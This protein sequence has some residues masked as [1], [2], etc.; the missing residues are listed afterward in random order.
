MANL[1]IGE[2]THVI[3]MIK[4]V[5]LLDVYAVWKAKTGLNDKQLNTWLSNLTTVEKTHNF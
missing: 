2:K 3:Y 1:Q 4:S 5:H